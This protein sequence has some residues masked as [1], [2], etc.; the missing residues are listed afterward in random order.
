MNIVINLI[1]IIKL[2]IDI[3]NFRFSDKK[4]IIMKISILSFK[5]PQQ[6]NKMNNNLKF[7]HKLFTSY[8]M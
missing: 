2:W 3:K 6:I 8:R 5:K 4:G 1:K 7:E